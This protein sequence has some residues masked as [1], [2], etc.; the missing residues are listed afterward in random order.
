MRDEDARLPALTRLLEPRRAG[1]LYCMLHQPHVMPRAGEVGLVEGDRAVVLHD[2]DWKQFEHWLRMR[3]DDGSVRIA[4]LRGELE[5]M[6]PSQEHEVSAADIGDLVIAFAFETGL[7]LSKYGS[8]TL[9]KKARKCAAEPDESFFI[10]PRRDGFP[11]IVIEVV[12]TNPLV[13]KLEVYW[14]LGILEVWRFNR[15]GTF[16]L[17]VRGSRAYAV[18]LRSKLVPGL[19]FSLLARFVGTPEPMKAVEQYRAAVRKSLR[20]RRA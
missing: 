14:E 5:L 4:Y 13:E 6:S 2:V 18:K 12:R 9:V 7:V 20:R 16:D 3:G 11:D 8:T 17:F 15:D 1:Y 10:G 19:D